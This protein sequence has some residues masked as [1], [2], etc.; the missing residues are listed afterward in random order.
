MNY[1]KKKRSKREGNL[2]KTAEKMKSFRKFFSFMK[3]R[4]KG[5]D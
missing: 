1:R 2:R 5:E 4:I 3:I